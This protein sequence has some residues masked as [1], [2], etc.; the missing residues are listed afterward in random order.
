MPTLGLLQSRLSRRI[1][2]WV[3]LSIVTIEGIIFVPA[4]FRRRSE[5]LRSLEALSEAVLFTIKGS[6]MGNIAPQDLLSN[7]LAG[8]EQA[9]DIVGAVLYDERGQPVASFGAALPTLEFAAVGSEQRSQLTA[10]GRYYDVAWP[11]D[12]FQD[13]YVLI[14]R[15]DATGVQREMR[16]YAIAIVGLVV[17]ISAFVTGVTM[18]VLERLLINPLLQLRDDLQLA[19]VALQQGQSPQFRSLAEPRHDE[20]GEVARAFGEMYERIAQEIRDRTAAEAALRAEQAKAN[21]LLLNILPAAIADRLKNNLSNR[22]AIADSFSE[23]TILFADIVGFTELASRMPPTDLVCRLNTVFSAF[24]GIAER[25]GLEKIKTIG[26]AYMVV[27]GLPRPMADH[28]AA[29]MQMAIDMQQA[30]KDFCQAGRYCFQ[31]RIGIH[32]GP[33]VAGVI[34]VKKF[35]YDLWG[36]AVNIA[37]RMESHGVCDR[38]QVSAAT[39]DLLRDRF[40]FEDRGLIKVKGRGQMRTYLLRSE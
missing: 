34:G 11:R 37:S 10:R 38:I 7:G 20:L 28:A 32:T 18:L 29:T 30:I 24:D 33:V 5:K 16:Q 12:R 21:Q 15:H 27:G 14:V 9:S 31:L 35:S 26:D 4:Y 1:V 19:G 17:L 3:F 13:R 36:D 22:G 2:A 6:M 40:S 8:V 25:H 23:V 39:Y